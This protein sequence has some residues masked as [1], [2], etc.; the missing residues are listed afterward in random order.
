M[1]HLEGWE[2]ETQNERQFNAHADAARRFADIFEKYDAKVTF[3]ARPEFVRASNKWGDNVMRE[4]NERGHGVG[5]HA[6]LGGNA[7]KIGQTQQEFN[8]ELQLMKKGFEE[9]T[10]I[11]I[12]HVSGI[13]SSLD[14]AEGAI[15]AGFDFTT[16]GVAYCVMSLPEKERPEEFKNCDSPLVCH[17]T[18]PYEVLDRIHPWRISTAEDW[19]NPDRKGELVY[20]A[21]ENALPGLFEEDA[22]IEKKAKDFNQKDIQNFT[23]RIDKALEYA[24]KDDRI[25]VIYPGF[26]IGDPD[27]DAKMLENWL[28]AIKPYVKSGR[29]EWKTLPEVYDEYLTWEATKDR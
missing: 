27:F 16:G 23:E 2:T 5:L 10:G 18:F 12:R 9:N 19:L 3:E 15:K 20:F 29:V 14:W 11:Q 22:G 21:A 7:R 28:T 24:E 1:T 13:C 17:D 25:S 6:D 8:D 4:L 26:S